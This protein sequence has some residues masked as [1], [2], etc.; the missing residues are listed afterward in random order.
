MHRAR[1][2]VALCGLVVVGTGCEVSS[3]GPRDRVKVEAGSDV[4]ATAVAD[5]I[6]RTMASAVTAAIADGQQAASTLPALFA[7][8]A[9]LSDETEQTYSGHAAIRRAF[10]QG[11]PPGASIDIRSQSVIGSGDLV[12]DMGTYTVRMPSPQGGT[13]TSMNGRY[14]VALQR[15]DDDSWKIVRQL[16]D[17][18]GTGGALPDGSAAPADTAASAPATAQPTA[19]RPAESGFTSDR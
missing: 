1:V 19:P 13:P 15:M 12:V 5:S 4:M 11:M 7:P 14:L 18:V 17:A 3:H 10:S 8:D 6:A 16:T 9:V 2:V